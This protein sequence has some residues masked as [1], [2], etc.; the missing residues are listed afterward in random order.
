MTKLTQLTYPEFQ[1]GTETKVSPPFNDI[2]AIT[3]QWMFTIFT[4]AL[5]WPWLLNS[6]GKNF[7]IKMRLRSPRIRGPRHKKP[8]A[9]RVSEASED[10]GPTSGRMKSNLVPMTCQHL[11][12]VAPACAQHNLNHSISHQNNK[13]GRIALIGL[14]GR[15][16]FILMI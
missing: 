2:K 11:I 4:R 6:R 3:F 12:K 14:E 16:S 8:S 9:E 7:Q 5:P 13:Y 10:E 1:F 15:K